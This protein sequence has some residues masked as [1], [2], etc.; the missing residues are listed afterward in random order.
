MEC[1]EISQEKKEKYLEMVR[2]CRE[3]ITEPKPLTPGEYWDY[4]N[5]VCPSKDDK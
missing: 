5:E 1:V 4:V 2:E 3:M